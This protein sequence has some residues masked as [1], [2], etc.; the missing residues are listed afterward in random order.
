MLDLYPYPFHNGDYSGLNVVYIPGEYTFASPPGTID[1]VVVC[2]VALV[3]HK[4]RPIL[5]TLPI[6]YVSETNP[7]GSIDRLET[8]RLLGIAISK[9][10]R[11]PSMSKAVALA[12]QFKQQLLHI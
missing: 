11:N 9:A 2:K 10:E 8:F 4:T 1:L 6:E 12:V 7:V 5:A 3:V